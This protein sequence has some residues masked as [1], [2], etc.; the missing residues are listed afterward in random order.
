MVFSQW[1]K[2]L[3]LTIGYSYTL[4]IILQQIII[5]VQVNYAAP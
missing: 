5:I 4:D 1:I 3:M 2:M